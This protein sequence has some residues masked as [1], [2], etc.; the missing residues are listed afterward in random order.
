ME[1]Y[2]YDP[3]RRKRSR[4]RKYD[5]RRTKRTRRRYDPRCYDPK[6][7]KKSMLG[8]IA[9]LLIGYVGGKV[10]TNEITQKYVKQAYITSQGQGFDFIDI[11]GGIGTAF[12]G[13]K[14]EIVKNLGYGLTLSGI[15]I[16]IPQSTTGAKAYDIGIKSS[17]NISNEVKL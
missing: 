12:L 8:E 16:S 13:K 7:R 10:I 1:E 4:R 14:Y 3:K 17:G 6:T 2:L 11:A 5:P 9:G 15:N